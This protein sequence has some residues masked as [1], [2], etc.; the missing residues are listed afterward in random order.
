MTI[1][2][3]R[4]PT[5]QPICL[6]S[7]HPCDRLC[8]LLTNCRNCSQCNYLSALDFNS[9][10]AQQGNANRFTTHTIILTN[11]KWLL[12][13]SGMTITQCQPSYSGERFP[14]L[15]LPFKRPLRGWIWILAF[16]SDRQR[17]SARLPQRPQTSNPVATVRVPPLA[18][19]R[20]SASK[21]SLD[22]RWILSFIR[23]Q[24]ISW[25]DDVL[26]TP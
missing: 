25:L 1:W 26:S 23:S 22:Y 6:L 4:P 8:P 21:I 9:K 2:R 10:R 20:R 3:P 5:K 13:P 7:A 14:T 17:A 15:V 24:Y 19:C 12:C 11:S 16:Y 18:H